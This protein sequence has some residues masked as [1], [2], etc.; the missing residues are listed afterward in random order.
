M[1]TQFSPAAFETATALGVLS[2][3][4]RLLLLEAQIGQAGKA[5]PSNTSES[6]GTSRT[7]LR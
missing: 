4:D 5:P 3:L 1:K 6:G 7:I 2:S